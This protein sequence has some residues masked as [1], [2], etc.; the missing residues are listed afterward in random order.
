MTALPMPNPSLWERLVSPF[1]ATGL[2][3]GTCAWEVDIH[4]HLVPG[5]DDGVR[6]AE[7]ALTCLEQLV[8]WGIR[9]VIT[10][11]HISLDW[12]PNKANTIREGQLFLQALIEA[13]QLPLTIEVAAEYLVDDSFFDL[14]QT[15][16]LLSFGRERY[17]LI[18]T[19]WASAPNRIDDILFRIKTHR[20]QPVLAH[21]ERYKYYHNNRKGLL[22][23]HET[24]CLFQLNWM[25][26]TGHYGAAIQKQARFL[27]QENLVD[28]I[29]SDL[30]Q[31]RDLRSIAR[32][33]GS[34]DL[35]LLQRRNLL[36]DS[37]R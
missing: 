7:Q 9:K 1:T 14:L 36:N 19:G 16:D 23:L 11:P 30:H 4:S 5:I 35:Q 31:P 3:A 2:R 27:L 15:E 17:L 33:F 12:Y 18:E 8:K 29:G 20:Y 25:S 6:D 37:L 32:L 28:F 26:F 21:P 13:H 10:T 22:H 24:G 34:N